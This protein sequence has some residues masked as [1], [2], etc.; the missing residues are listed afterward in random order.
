MSAVGSQ[1]AL[2]HP[3][4]DTRTSV[5]GTPVVVTDVNDLLDGWVSVV[6]SVAVY[7]EVAEPSHLNCCLMVTGV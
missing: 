6:Q 4:A 7:L 2:L 1:V 5:V 3:A